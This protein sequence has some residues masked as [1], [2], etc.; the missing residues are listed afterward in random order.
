M[1]QIL[2][3]R[4]EFAD[5][6]RR[7]AKRRTQEHVA[8]LEERRQRP[9][10]LERGKLRRHIVGRGR[11][12]GVMRACKRQ[13]LEIAVGHGAAEALLR[14]PHAE[15]G[16]GGHDGRHHHGGIGGKLRR[17]LL[18]MVAEPGKLG[19][20]LPRHGGDFGIDGVAIGRLVGKGDAQAAGIA[21]DLLQ[22]W[23]LRRRG[24]VGA[25]RL[26]S[27]DRI[28]HRRA[29]AH[30]DAHDMAAGKS[31][32]AF[33]AIGTERRARAARLQ[34]EYAGGGSRNPYRSA[35]VAG[36][37]DGKNSRGNGRG[38][39]AGRAAR[40]VREIPGISGRAEQTGLGGRQQS[41][42]RAG[43]FSEDRN[44]GIEE[45][46]GEGAGMVG[47]IVLEDTG[48]RR[49]PCTLKKL[50]ILQDKRHAGKGA[51]GKAV[52]D[53]PLRVVV[54]FDDHRVD[55]RIDLGGAG[56]RFVQQLP[57][58]DLLVADEF[59]ESHPVI[60]AVFLEGH[61][62]TRCREATKPAPSKPSLESNQPSTS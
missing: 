50:Q 13:Y 35:A 40:G 3:H 47:D 26:R 6:Q 59:G 5:P 41:E 11:L 52:V 57:G 8:G 56:D 30:A 62:L 15:R 61:G 7:R 21:A 1:R 2:R 37:R 32:P 58:L 42:F 51:V 36:M 31:A 43:A 18:D 46:P 49:G 9:R 17:A 45:T 55:L 14:K 33:A 48:A 38:R 54:M 22:V 16:V 10:D 34:S 29:V 44:A 24:D 20:D 60:A 27:V 4:V 19:R 28:Q 25:R 12:L 23:P 39:A 53:L